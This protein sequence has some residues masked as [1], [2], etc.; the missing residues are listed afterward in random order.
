MSADTKASDTNGKGYVNGADTTC[1][2]G[3]GTAATTLLELAKGAGKSVGAVTTT[4]VT[5]ATPAATFS[6]I[7][8]RDGENQIAAQGTPGNTLYNVA[9]KDGL[10]VLLGGGRRHFLPQGTTGS[11]RTD[12]TDLVAQFQAANYTY[13]STGTQLAAIDPASTT[14]LL[15]LFTL[16]HMSYELDRVKKS[17]DEPGRHDREGHP[18]AAEERQGLFPDGGRRPHRPRTARHQRQARAGRCRRV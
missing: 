18:R 16:D 11:K 15:G 8:H 12:T 6:H 1:P 14:K 9:L 10:D 3:N 4:R 17:L 5:H 13:V 7:C 2:V